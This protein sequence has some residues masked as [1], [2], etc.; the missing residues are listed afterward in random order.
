MIN[1]DKM[2]TAL[3]SWKNVKKEVLKFVDE[4]KL[5]DLQ[6]NAKK[7]VTN[8]QNDIKNFTGKDFSTFKRKLKVEK[9]QIEKMVDKV[10]KAELI[11]AKKFVNEQKKEL[12]KLHKKIEE[13]IPPTAEMKKTVKRV[14]KKVKKATKKVAK[15]TTKKTTAKKKTSAN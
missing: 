8:A 12:K 1:K 2:K 3:K 7:L 13:L 11:K 5:K 15:K 14:V 4:N 10:V 9:R 6:T